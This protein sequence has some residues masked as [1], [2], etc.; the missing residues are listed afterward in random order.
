MTDSAVLLRARGMTK[1]FGDIPVL[2]DATVE[3][4]AGEVHAFLGENGAGKSTLAK[5]IAGIHQPTAGQIEVGDKTV[6]FSGPRDAARNGIA[7]IPQ[8]P[9]TF[10]DLS[11]AENLFVGRQPTRGGRV[12]WKALYAEAARLFETLGIDLDPRQS[13]RGL[14]VADRQMLE[15]AGALSQDARILL[16]DETTASL[17]PGEVARLA[18]LIRRLR[19]EGRALVFIGHRMEEIFDLCDRATILRDGRVVG[20]RMVQETTPAELLNL[21][22]GREV[23][24][25]ASRESTGVGETILEVKG[26]TLAPRF[27]DISF[28][29]RKGEVVGL[30]GLV[31][32]G[33]TD[34]AC[35]L[36]G[37]LSPTAGTIQV[38]G[39]AVTI[40]TPE[41]ALRLGIALVPEDRQR[42][43]GFLPLSLWENATLTVLPRISPGG[44]LKNAGARQTTAGWSKKLAVRCR[45]IEQPL[46]ELSGGNQQKIVLAKWLETKPRILLLD[47]PTRGID[48]RAKGEVHRLIAELAEQGMAVLLISSDL[49]EVLTLSDRVLVLRAGRLV[50]EMTREEAT[51]EAVIAAAG[52][53]LASKAEAS[54]A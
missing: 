4:R 19:D 3:L 6:S 39:K 45:N 30:A 53:A 22:V 33:R 32:A 52:V 40:R 13:A 2:E 21:M 17:T 41:D 47:E 36:F 43:G 27:D 24:I 54:E 25:Y 14:S 29:L 34:I 28:T 46:A 11:V 31:G 44:W 10:P 7:L 16:L 9:R 23:D 49:P 37:L 26:L 8:E 50:R 51:P 15:M 35:A 48:V 1:A 12:D 20:E 18:V 42:Q 38:D 5:L